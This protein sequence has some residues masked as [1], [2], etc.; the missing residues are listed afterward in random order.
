ME[1]V[2][3]TYILYWTKPFSNPQLRLQNIITQYLQ[4][5]AYLEFLFGREHARGS[6]GETAGSQWGSV[7]KPS[8]A[9]N[10]FTFW[11]KITL[12]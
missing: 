5:V 3:V 12:F 9:C 1:M 10:F 4:L 7:A 2:L 6:G 8:A 11:S